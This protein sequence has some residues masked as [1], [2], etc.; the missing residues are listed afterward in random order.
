MKRNLILAAMA[1]VVLSAV[2]ASAQLERVG[3]TVPANG[4]PAW[5]QD[6]TGLTLEFCQPLS[7][8]ELDGGWCLLLAA[9]TTFP[10]VFPTQFAD[11][12]FYFAADSQLPIPGSTALLVIGL[13]A[14]FA[15][16]P[17]IPGDQIVFA[18]VRIRF[19]APATGTYTIY[20]PYGSNT[21]EGVAGQRVFFTEDIGI[22]CQGQFDCAL[23]GRIGPFLLP[24]NTPGGA[25]LPAVSGPV[26]GKLYIA[27]PARD[28]PVT[29]SRVLDAAGIPQNYFRIVG[30]GGLDVSTS[31]FTLQGRIF[32]G[33][34][35]GKVTVDRASYAKSTAGNKLDVFA[36]AFPATQT[37]VPGLPTPP[38]IAPVLAFYEGACTV[39]P[40]GVLGPPAGLAGVQMYSNQSNYY[41]QTQPVVVPPAVCVGDLTAKDVNGQVVPLFSQATV[42]DQVT[43]SQ[44][45][46]DNASATLTVAATS[47][48]AVTPTTLNVLGYGAMVNGALTVNSLLAPPSKVRVSSSNGGQSELLISTGIGGTAPPLPIPIANN[49]AMSIAEDS[50]AAI[51]DVL[52]NDTVNGGPIVGGTVAITAQPRL[53]TAVLVGNQISYTPARNASGTDSLSYTVTVLDASGLPLTSPAAFV[54]IAITPVNDIPVAVADTASGTAVAPFSFNVLVN[55]TDP[56]GAADLSHAAS[57]SAVTGPAAATVS[58]GVGGVVTFSATVAGTYTFT[59]VAVD[60]AGAASAPATVTV[61]VLGNETLVVTQADFVRSQLRWRVAGTSTLAAG[62]TIS[63]AYDN[64]SLRPLGTSLA[65]YLIGTAQVLAD[66]TWSMDLRLTSATDPR[67]PNATNVFVIRPSRIRVSSPLGGFATAAIVLK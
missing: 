47:S 16:G 39:S 64:G 10:E 62:Q 59:Y 8:A 31:N 33:S 30:P 48:D 27:D 13:E 67:N 46:F 66:G 24:S 28:G 22:T 1:G 50:P 5:Y 4:F 34:M 65:G 55:D 2:P 3:P 43:I 38:A 41:A 52:A 58:G 25:E 57:F 21:L 49:D 56:D 9:D 23:N 12:H 37:R 7:Q 45:A 14:A 42:T 15:V 29:G 54:T 17:P 44:A 51:L 36:S 53:G 11:E 6:T 63:I 60:L 35:A 61:N 32:T 20:H 19:D 18:R 40:T 26:P